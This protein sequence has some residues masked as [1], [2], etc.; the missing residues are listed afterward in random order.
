M[1]RTRRVKHSARWSGP[2]DNQQYSPQPRTYALEK[3]GLG[4]RKTQ[5]YVILAQEPRTTHSTSNSETQNRRE[6]EAYEVMFCHLASIGWQHE[7]IEPF[8]TD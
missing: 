5:A 2:G 6:T 4:L 3:T 1:T 7:D 8:S